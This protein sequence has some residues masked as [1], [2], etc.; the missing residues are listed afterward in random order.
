M[1]TALLPLLLIV[2]SPAIAQH[3]TVSVAPEKVTQLQLFVSVPFGM[4]R[5][6]LVTPDSLLINI[7]TIEGHIHFAKA[8]TSSEHEIL[9]SSFSK[10]YLSSIKSSYRPRATGVADA[11]IYNITL[12][13]GKTTKK[14]SVCFV[15]WEPLYVFSKKLNRLL[16]ADFKIN[17]TTTYFY[18]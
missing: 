14:T 8:L 12:V 1:R 3:L 10:I 9:L 15:R 2:V 17:Y 16:P 5:E 18:K 6:Y 13:K 11:A 4:D 7:K